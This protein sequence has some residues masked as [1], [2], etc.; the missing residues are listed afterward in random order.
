MSTAVIMPKFEMAQETGKVAAWLKAEGDVVKKGEAILEV[1]TDKVNMEVEA[2]AAGILTGIAAQPGEIVPVGR[3]IAYIVKPGEAAAAGAA[4]RGARFS[5]LRRL[6]MTEDARSASGWLRLSCAPLRMT[7]RPGQ[8]AGRRRSLRV[9]PRAW[10]LTW[11]RCKA[12][13]RAGR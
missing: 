1:E 2:P 4:E 9:W 3:P 12:P 11:P 7:G 5:A 13:G 6:R 8:P 10:A